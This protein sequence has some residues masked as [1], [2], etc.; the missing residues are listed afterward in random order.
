MS[1]FQHVRM[2]CFSEADKISQHERDGTIRNPVKMS[3]FFSWSS[4]SP[5][6]L[7]LF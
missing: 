4:M 2:A 7:S 1:N 5:A 3:S 6:F